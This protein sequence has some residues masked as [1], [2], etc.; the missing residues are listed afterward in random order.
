MYLDLPPNVPH[1]YLGAFICYEGDN[2]FEYFVPDGFV[3]SMDSCVVQTRDYN[4]Y[5]TTVIELKLVDPTL[6]TKKSSL[7]RTVPIVLNM[8]GIKSSQKKMRLKPPVNPRS[9]VSNNFIAIDFGSFS[10][11]SRITLPF[12]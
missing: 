7:K 6:D 4:D 12:S 10:L 1:D 3:K 5:S 11:T 9:T 2:S 8:F